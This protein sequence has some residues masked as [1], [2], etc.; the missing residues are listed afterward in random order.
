MW[1]RIAKL[2][3]QNPYLADDFLRLCF[4]CSAEMVWASSNIPDHQYPRNAGTVLSQLPLWW[5][6]TVLSCSVPVLGCSALCVGSWW[7][8]HKSFSNL[9]EQILTHDK[10]SSYSIFRNHWWWD[11]NVKNASQIKLQIVSIDFS[12][13]ALSFPPTFLCRRKESELGCGCLWAGMP[14]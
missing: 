5:A 9:Y 1:R 11:Q 14:K 6:C 12:F 8:P 4:A 3:I 10:K 13:P 7:V 2:K